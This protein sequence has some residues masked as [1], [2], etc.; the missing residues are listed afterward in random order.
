[1]EKESESFSV[2]QLFNAYM[3]YLQFGFCT[4]SRNLFQ[5]VPQ[6]PYMGKPIVLTQT[7]TPYPWKPHQRVYACGQH[8]KP[9]NN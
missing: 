6:E 4:T 3:F 2:H 9:H 1:M 5:L 7:L 8:Y